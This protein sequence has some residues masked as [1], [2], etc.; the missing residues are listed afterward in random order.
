M[1][2][3]I[4]ALTAAITL[5]AA[6]P[7]DAQ[8]ARGECAAPPTDSILLATH[9]FAACQVDREARRRGG[10]PKLDWKQT[11]GNVDP[12]SCYVAEFEFV[13]DTMGAVEEPSIRLLSSTDGD[14]ED[15][16]RES[17]SKLRYEPARLA[18][19]KVRQLVK[20]Q[21]KTTIRVMIRS[22]GPSGVPGMPRDV[23]RPPAC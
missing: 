1:R 14:H 13:V 2:L 15:A 12:G 11:P 19:R 9:A 5:A 21:R 16:V 3:P 22:T 23:T 17:I 7:L 4:L 6:S 18:G 20:Y 10:E 8:A